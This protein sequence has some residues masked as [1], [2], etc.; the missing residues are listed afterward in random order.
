LTGERHPAAPVPL[1]GRA[2]IRNGAE[3]VHLAEELYVRLFRLVMLLTIAGSALS[4]WLGGLGPPG[5]PGVV[6]FLFAAAGT[7]LATFGLARPRQLYCW[8]RYNRVHQL[9]PAL[10][11]VAAVSVNGAGSPS[12]WVAL[13]LL[14]IVAD[15][16]STVLAVG[17]ALVA[18]AAYL[19]ATAATGAQL[20]DHGDAGILAAAVALP[21]NTAVGRLAAEVFA[22]FV[23][24]F[25]RVQYEQN[26]AERRRPVRVDSL[27]PTPQS[28]VAVSRLGTPTGRERRSAR[29]SLLTSRQLEVA[30]LA[31]DGLLEGEIAECLGISVR[32][33]ERL[34]HDARERVGAATTS[35]LVALLVT[36]RL[37][38]A[39]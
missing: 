18:A 9:A 39:L 21:I 5:G 12:W 14:W 10:L 29:T 1:D 26:I 27:A 23:L 20:V 15:I 6:T 19:A 34:L 3:L 16:G 31:R 11:A 28:E 37:V 36:G 35:E 4:L 38:P 17:A 32:Q 30:L 7:A 22:R 2:L 8:L 24:N 13:P 25:H 33:V